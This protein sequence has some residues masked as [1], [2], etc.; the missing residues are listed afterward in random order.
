MRFLT[1][2]N[3]QGPVLINR[4]LREACLSFEATYPIQRIVQVQQLKAQDQARVREEIALADVILAQPVWNSVVP[5]VTL[6][7]L[8][9]L[10]EGKRLELFPAL[11]WDAIFATSTATGWKGVAGYPF[12]QTEDMAIAAAFACGLSVTEAMEAWHG[13]PVLETAVLRDQVEA[14]LR[15]FETRESA[16]EVTIPMSDFY[17][18]SWQGDVLHYVKSHPRAIVYE[19][20]VPRLVQRLELGE[21]DLSRVTDRRGNG[22]LGLPVKRWVHRALELTCAG[23]FDFGR[24]DN[25]V[26]PLGEVFERLWGFYRAQGAGEVRKRG[27]KQPSFRAAMKRYGAA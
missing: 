6:P 7:V 19:T 3:C 9:K 13:V 17:R 22:Q 8:R 27:S 14:N 5:E 18:Q 12:G 24:L 23:E 2:A 16:A 25:Q 26:V 21:V 15:G 20:L 4:F 10:V 1:I 11:H